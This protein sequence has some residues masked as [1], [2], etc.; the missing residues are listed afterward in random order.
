MANAIDWSMRSTC[1]RAHVG[2][3]V[4]RDSR[5]LVTGYNGAPAGMPHCT[6]DCDCMQLMGGMMT[7][8]GTDWRTIHTATCNSQQ[9]CL[10]V[11]HAEANAI[12]F[13]A[14]HGAKLDGAEMHTTRMPCNACAQLIINAGIR[15]V[16]YL[17]PH[18]ENKGMTLLMDAGVEVLQVD[19]PSFA[20][21]AMP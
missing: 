10:L 1:D 15:R 16:A 5:V 6:H 4:S 2:C 17:H 19:P 14:R 20:A 11:V 9:P 21:R 13:A 12:A 3:V 18:R 8:E 7:K